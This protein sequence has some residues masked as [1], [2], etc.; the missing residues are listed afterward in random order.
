VDGD[1]P[2]ILLFKP[3]TNTRKIKNRTRIPLR[4]CTQRWV[5]SCAV[6]LLSARTC[7]EESPDHIRSCPVMPGS[8]RCYRTLLIIPDIARIMPDVVRTYRFILHNAEPWS[9]MPGVALFCSD[10]TPLHPPFN[11]RILLSSGRILINYT[12]SCHP[13]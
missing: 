6:P 2:P 12:R 9:S 13:P 5:K 8:C 7:P 4:R 11:G 3:W 1:V 10:L